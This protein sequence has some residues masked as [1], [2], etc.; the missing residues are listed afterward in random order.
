MPYNAG[1]DVFSQTVGTPVPTVAFTLRIYSEIIRY[2]YPALLFTLDVFYDI[3]MILR[4]LIDNLELTAERNNENL[5]YFTRSF[6]LP[7]ISW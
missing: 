3:M 1:G 2:K 7:S 6:Y 4:R 5:R